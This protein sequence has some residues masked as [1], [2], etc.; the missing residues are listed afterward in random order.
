MTGIVSKSILAP[1]KHRLYIL[2]HFAVCFGDLF[3][4]HSDSNSNI[5]HLDATAAW[6]RRAQDITGDDGV[7]SYDNYCSLPELCRMFD[8]AG[9]AVVEKKGGTIGLPWVFNYFRLGKFLE[10]YAPSFLK[11][12]FSICIPIENRL[13]TLAP[14]LAI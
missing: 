5:E 12:F 8:K 4:R 2:S 3:S 6:L 1:L 13:A 11:Y 14:F 10:R 7:S 9:L